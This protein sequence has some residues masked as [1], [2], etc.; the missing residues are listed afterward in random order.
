METVTEQPWIE[1]FMG[2]EIATDDPRYESC[3]AIAEVLWSFEWRYAG[4][5]DGCPAADWR[6]E[7]NDEGVVVLTGIVWVENNDE[8]EDE[9]VHPLSF[10]IPVHPFRDPKD[11]IRE[12]IHSFLS[13]EADERM[14]F[15]GE[16]LFY[17]H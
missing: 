17:P 12:A 13:H 3:V 2:D 16:R 6:I 9:A 7:R 1:A 4:N 5:A 11:Q 8:P 10:S 15:N 14:F